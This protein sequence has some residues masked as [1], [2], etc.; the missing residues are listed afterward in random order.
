MS[1]SKAVIAK[2]KLVFNLVK[3]VYLWY[4]SLK[5]IL[6]TRIYFVRHCEAMG[7][8]MRIFQGLTDLD[9]SDMGKKQLEFLKKRFE[10]IKLDKIY[11]S[12]LIRTRKTA[13]AIK[14]DSDIEIIPLNGLIEINGGVVEGR[15]FAE[16]FNEIEGLA[17][18]WD[19]HPEDFAPP[20]GEPMRHAYERIYN[21]L[22]FVIENNQGKTV[23]CAT[24]G[25]VTRCLLCKLLTDDIRKLKDIPWSENTAVSLFEVDDNGNITVKYYNDTTHLPSELL[26]VRNRIATF[27]KGDTK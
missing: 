16:A 12:P 7:N 23:A 13:E 3:K 22:K 18:T 19:N 10:N 4:N 14:G 1:F 2:T 6:L 26:P 17:D 24:H 21:T 11:T 5:V 27:M 9:V 25:G 8:V 20:L 15:K